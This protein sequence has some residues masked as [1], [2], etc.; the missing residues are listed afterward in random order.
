MGITT[1]IDKVADTMHPIQCQFF[2]LSFATREHQ[3]TE[4]LP[5]LFPLKSLELLKA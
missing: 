5:V 3:G 4:G 2:G 1:K